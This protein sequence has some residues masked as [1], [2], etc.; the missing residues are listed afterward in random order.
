[1]TRTSA[2]V[3]VAAMPILSAIAAVPE[4][5]CCFLPMV[6]PPCFWFSSA[7]TMIVPESR[8]RQPGGLWSLNFVVARLRDQAFL[9]E[10]A[11]VARG[12]VGDAT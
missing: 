8:A 4:I 3:A 12:K 9:V 5:Q 11:S 7:E 1:M 6:E 2:A 10:K